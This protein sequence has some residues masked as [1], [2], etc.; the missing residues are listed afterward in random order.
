MPLKKVLGRGIICGLL[1]FLSQICCLVFLKLFGIDLFVPEKIDRLENT[2]TT[3]LLVLIVAPVVEEFVFRGP[4]W[5]LVDLKRPRYLILTALAV[6]SILFGLVHVSNYD[7]PYSI[8]A[9]AYVVMKT[10]Q[11]V[12][13]GAAVIKYNSL[14]VSITAH[15]F[16]NSG[17]AVFVL[18][19]LV[20]S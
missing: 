14:A 7:S 18:I 17:L 4:L 3:V 15:C 6:T 1:S 5:C 2:L 13:F 16:V 11:G 8:S 19:N 10:I 9:I 20:K 12:I